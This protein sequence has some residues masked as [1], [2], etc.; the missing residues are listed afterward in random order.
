MC[1]ERKNRPKSVR[2][3]KLKREIYNYNEMY[4]FAREKRASRQLIH[5]DILVKGWEAAFTGFDIV[6]QYVEEIRR[7]IKKE[8]NT[9]KN[10]TQLAQFTQQAKEFQDECDKFSKI[11]EKLAKIVYSQ[12]SNL[13]LQ[14][15]EKNQYFDEKNKRDEERLN[16]QVEKLKVT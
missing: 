4:K 6:D 11:G 16:K 13:Y 3:D 1:F 7:K 14:W 15:E 5:R 12:S 9:R 2:N 8:G 10:V